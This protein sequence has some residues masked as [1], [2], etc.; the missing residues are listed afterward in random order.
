MKM[1]LS[2]LTLLLCAALASAQCPSC[3]GGVCVPG[4]TCGPQGCP[5]GICRPASGGPL[6]PRPGPLQA[7]L[8]PRP[9]C[10]GPHCPR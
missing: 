4:I 5:G 8:S 1:L 3:P 6:A 7:I 2:C 10:V 9:A